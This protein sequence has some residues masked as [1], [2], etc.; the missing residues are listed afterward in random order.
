[1]LTFTAKNLAIKFEQANRCGRATEDDI[2]YCVKA[3]GKQ[4]KYFI[5]HKESLMNK[6]NT[7][8]DETTRKKKC[9]VTITNI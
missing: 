7:F 3:P 4:K 2:T 5:M 1:M 8:T 6:I 9:N